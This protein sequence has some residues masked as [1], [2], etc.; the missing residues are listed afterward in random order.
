M[1]KAIAAIEK[2]MGVGFMQTNAAGILRKLI[3]GNSHVM[4]SL[5]EEDRDTLNV[6]LQGGQPSAGY[7]PASGEIVGILKQLKDTMAG[8]LAETIKAEEAAIAAYEEL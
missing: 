2:G 5:G 1:T 7:A 6:F 3:G 4:G 8:D